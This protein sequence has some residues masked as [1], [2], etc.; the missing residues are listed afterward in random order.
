MPSKS[1]APSK[2]KA[3]SLD[4]VALTEE[5]ETPAAAWKRHQKNCWICRSVPSF[6]WHSYCSDGTRMYEM[7]LALGVL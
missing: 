6:N 7:A 3:K 2:T 5:D 1:K 4:L